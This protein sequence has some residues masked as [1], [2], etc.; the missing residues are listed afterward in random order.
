VVVVRKN[1]T[2]SKLQRAQV[3]RLQGT[4]DHHVLGPV[5]GEQALLDEIRYFF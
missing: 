5:P 3:A 1:I 4:G 2:K